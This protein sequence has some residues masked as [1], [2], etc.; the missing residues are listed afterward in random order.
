MPSP[1]SRKKLL[2]LAMFILPVVAVK[3]STVVLIGPGPQ[4]AQATLTDPIAA[5]PPAIAMPTPRWTEK[6]LA[7]A[8]HIQALRGE[9]FGNTPLLYEKQPEPPPVIEVIV[10]P[11][12]PVIDPVPVPVLA[13]IPTFTLQAVMSGG[14]GKTALIDGR[15]YREGERIR[16]ADWM[17]VII[18]N[19]NRSVT[20][21]E[22]GGDRSVRINVEL[23]RADRD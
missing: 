13:P 5:N 16:G 4:S 20:L 12:P 18:D 21:G 19:D 3:I 10:E 23:P 7:A 2:S 14:R 11:P 1:D 17:V 15:P 9:P 8:R 22:I 6:Q